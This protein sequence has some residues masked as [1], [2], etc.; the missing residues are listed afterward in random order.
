MRRTITRIDA[1]IPI[2]D[3][4][5]YVNEQFRI[6]LLQ[7]YERGLIIGT[8]SPEGVV[9]AEQG[10]EYMDETGLTGAVKYIKQLANIAGD[11]SSGWVA[12]G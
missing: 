11:R 3:Q 12:I 2:N 1:S 5:G 8:G 10:Q 6:F 7:V 4:N 9:E